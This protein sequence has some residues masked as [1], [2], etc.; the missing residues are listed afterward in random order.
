MF[1]TIMANES[2]VVAPIDPE[3]VRLKDI[4]LYR[5]NGQLIAHRVVSIEKMLEVSLTTPRSSVP[6]PF[7][8]PIKGESP[9]FKRSAPQA[10]RSFKR[11]TPQAQRSNSSSAVTP[12]P[13]AINR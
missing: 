13:S 10:Q 4:I 8:L 2:I 1:P 3:T 7:R 11:S 6:A 12:R 9:L 5:T